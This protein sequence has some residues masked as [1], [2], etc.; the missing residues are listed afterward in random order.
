MVKAGGL[1]AACLG[2]TL[3]ASSTSDGPTFGH[4][5]CHI[6]SCGKDFVVL[7]GQTCSARH[8]VCSSWDTQLAG[9][10]SAPNPVP[11]AASGSTGAIGLM[12]GIFP[13]WPIPAAAGTHG[14]APGSGG[15]DS[16]TGS[17]AGGSWNAGSPPEFG[18]IAAPFSNMAPDARP[19][20]AG[21]G[22]TRGLGSTQQQ[23]GSD[24]GDSNG[25]SAGGQSGSQGPG[26]SAGPGDDPPGGDGDPIDVSGGSGGPPD[27]SD[28]TDLPPIELENPQDPSFPGGGNPVLTSAAPAVHEPAALG[29]LGVGLLMLALGRWRLRLD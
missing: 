21:R 5:V 20:V 11:S 14:T 9:E 18:A 26:Q 13:R 1:L 12:P 27:S 23:D 4:G 15:Q 28:P 19:A 22:S 8:P 2:T 10:P 6:S 17:N 29:L 25:G 16:A 7:P 3:L 24:G